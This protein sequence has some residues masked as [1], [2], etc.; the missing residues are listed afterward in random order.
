MDIV[1]WKKMKSWN[2]KYILENF[3]SPF[4]LLTLQDSTL[5]LS[6]FSHNPGDALKI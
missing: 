3:Y 5:F 4:Q 2:L 1:F 6:S